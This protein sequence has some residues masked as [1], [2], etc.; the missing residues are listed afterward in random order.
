MALSKSVYNSASGNGPYSIGFN[1]IDPSHV[2]VYVNGS[3]VSSANYSIANGQITFSSGAPSSQQLIIQRET[4]GRT[5]ATK[6]VRVVDFVNG[7]TLNEADMDNASLQALYIAQESMDTGGGALPLDTLT[8]TWDAGSKK[9][10]NVSNPTVAQDA[11]T[12]SY[13]DTKFTSVDALGKSGGQWT[14]ANLKIQNL[15]DPAAAADAVNKSYVDALSIYGGAAMQPQSW[16]FNIVSGDWTSYTGGGYVLQRTLSG[17]RSTDANTLIVTF[18]GV[19]Q[20]PLSAYT[21]AGDVIQLFSA[22]A[23]A[24]RLVV[25]N[26]G[27][28]R[29]TLSPATST[30]LGSVIVGSNISV[31]ASGTINI[32]TLS[33]VATSGAYT[34]LSGKPTLGT[35]SSKDTPASGNASATQVV[36]GSDSRLTD[37]RTPAAHTHSQSDVT[38]LVSGLAALMPL[39]GGLFTGAPKF[40]SD[41]DTTAADAGLNTL[42]RKS[43]LDARLTAISQSPSQISINVVD[44]PHSGVSDLLYYIDP[45]TIPIN[46]LRIWRFTPTAA[47]NIKIHLQ[48]TAGNPAWVIGWGIGSNNSSTPI[49][50]TFIASTSG[51]TGRAYTSA[52]FTWSTTALYLLQA[53]SL[54]A[55]VGYACVALLRYQ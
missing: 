31:D 15:A 36:L 26:F 55:P 23:S 47:G 6:N 7:S 32:P 9:I 51:T 37:T 13:V 19:L 16:D 54:N 52:N 4:P 12:K 27:V 46:T 38:G 1:Y 40:A 3:L 35:A 24:A 45:A 18:G 2:K 29:N 5:D 10:S 17:L 50:S 41:P 42:V 34:D 20:S 44:V 28:S 33:T 25:R 21:L 11:A 14:A 49:P 43:Y 30:Q 48:S 22:T 8:G 39:A 53:N